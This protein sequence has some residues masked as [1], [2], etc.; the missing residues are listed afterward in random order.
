MNLQTNRRDLK[1]DAQGFDEVKITT[2]P[3]YKSSGLSGN[4]WRISGLCQ[5]LRKGR[6][7]HEFYMSNV[8]SCVKALPAEVMKA[9]DEGKFFYAGEEDFCDQEGCSEKAK[10]VYRAKYKW[11]NEQSHHEKIEL[12]A[13]EAPIRMFCERHSMRGDCG[14]YDADDNYEL[15]EGA[16]IS[17]KSEDI[18]ESV[19]GGTIQV[20]NIDDVPNMVSEKI[21]EIKSGL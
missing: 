19:F 7:I 20:D 3:R 13:E 8:E 12:K 18:K 15:L 9:G 14:M 6:V 2:V 11:C 17:P 1:P 4:E 16:I 21:K 5:L 10:V